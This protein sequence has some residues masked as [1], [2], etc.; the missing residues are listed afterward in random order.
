MRFH[1]QHGKYLRI[2]LLLTT[3]ILSTTS[4][5]SSAQPRKI[6]FFESILTTTVDL[7]FKIAGKSSLG[8]AKSVHEIKDPILFARVQRLLDLL[9]TTSPNP[10]VYKTTRLAL[11]EGTSGEP[12]AFSTGRTLYVTRELAQKLNDNELIATLAHELAHGELG[13]LAEKTG[14]RYAALWVHIWQVIKSDFYSLTH[15]GNP[16]LLMEEL[17]EKGQWKRI[18]ELVDHASLGQELEADCVAWRWLAYMNQEGVDV[19]PNDI[20]NAIL[21]LIGA[22]HLESLDED[23]FMGT[24]VRA[25]LAGNC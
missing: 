24:R 8:F 9:K 19:F 2:T 1:S 14:F 7:A 18:L 20:A 3:L 5:A 13:H 25:I 22:P 12:N 4:S 21:K 15:G 6:G 16:D 11:I 10:L 23:P 17:W